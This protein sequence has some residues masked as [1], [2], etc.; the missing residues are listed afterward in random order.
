LLIKTLNTR[1]ETPVKPILRGVAGQTRRIETGMFF[2]ED[3][4]NDFN[5]VFLD[6]NQMMGNILKRKRNIR[7]AFR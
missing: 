6:I 2:E 1:D 7:K 5:V 3:T 4:R